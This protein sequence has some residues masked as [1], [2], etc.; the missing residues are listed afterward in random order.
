MKRFWKTHGAGEER[1]NEAPRKETQRVQYDSKITS[2]ET[3]QSRKTIFL[4]KEDCFCSMRY[5]LAHF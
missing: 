2:F 5:N 3:F 4:L 1:E